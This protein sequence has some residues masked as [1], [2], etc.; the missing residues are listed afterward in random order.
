MSQRSPDGRFRLVYW[1]Q[2]PTG[3][4]ISGVKLKEVKTDR[5]IWSDPDDAVYG[6]IST[7]WSP[8]GKRLALMLASK[9][10]Q[11]LMI[12][13][14]K[15]GRFEEH[16]VD[17]P[18]PPFQKDLGPFYDWGSDSVKAVKWLD[19]DTVALVF[20]GVLIH[21]ANTQADSDKRDGVNYEYQAVL[22]LPDS[23]VTISEEGKK[24]EHWKD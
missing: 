9:R 20:S 6:G 3:G 15:Q 24:L 2:K 22:S 5:V 1:D 16:P 19:E 12:L 23:K 4:S 18:V 14:W 17:F 7:L 21:K 8:A 11:R 13:E 10:N